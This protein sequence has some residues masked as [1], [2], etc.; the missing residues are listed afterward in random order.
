MAITFVNKSAFASGTAGLSVG[1]VASVQADDLLLLFVE[2]ANQAIT[3][4]SGGWAQVTTSPQSTGTAAAAGG[5][6]LTV[7]YLWATG[8]DSTTTVADSGDHTN[9]I[10]I[11]YRGVDKVTP[12]D[13]T[14]VGGIKTPASTTATFPAITTVTDNALVVLSSALDLDAASTT[15]TGTPTN[16]N[17]TGLV[18]R[19]D[20]TVTSGVGG[21]LVIID[22]T[23]ASAGNTGTTTATVTSTIQVYLTIALREENDVGALNVTESGSD[24][25]AASG[26]V[27]NSA[28]TGSMAVSEV[29]NDTFSASGTVSSPAIT[30]SLSATETGNDTFSGTG[31]VVV[32]GSLSASEVGSDTF[33]GSGS[34]LVQ[35]SFSATET[36]NDTFSANGTV[37][38]NTVT[39]VLSATESGDDV[40]EG[41]GL[42][43][44]YGGLAANESGDDSFSSSGNVVVIGSFGATE[45]ADQLGSYAVDGYVVEGYTKDGWEGLV[46][47]QGGLSVSETGDDSFSSSGTVTDQRSNAG[48]TGGGIRRSKILEAAKWI[49]ELLDRDTVKQTEQVKKVK[50]RLKKVKKP[51]DL[52]DLQPIVN[53][54][55]VEVQKQKKLADDIA[56]LNF[57]INELKLI[58]EQLDDEEEALLML[59]A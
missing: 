27:V 29:G 35:G 53:A 20:Q 50:A 6:R 22:G 41:S 37:S 44:I 19:H 32:S 57:V 16:A 56:Q 21:G 59:M 30:G 42:I 18:E 5:V 11:A 36:G 46:L 48:I 15:T 43:L 26:T 58:K 49:L 34:V 39:G 24:T 25:F 51:E 28:I 7:F 38:T 33:S 14:P 54:A 17:L 47:I 4:P 12:F 10:K 23:K 2:S 8:A 9:A 1:A 40:F 52:E 45:E 31:N 13:A 55:I 3:T